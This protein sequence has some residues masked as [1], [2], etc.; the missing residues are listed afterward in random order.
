MPANHILLSVDHVLINI[1]FVA[2]VVFTPMTSAYWPWWKS[3]WGR[4]IVMLET[5]IA[6]DLLASW[7]FIDFGIASFILQWVTAVFLALTVS[8]IVWR[9]IM[10]WVEQRKGADDDDS[11]ASH[12]TAADGRPAGA[13]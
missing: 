8:I 7:L 3:W 6:G 10:I 1:A 4:N 9:A 11:A 13:A 2:S 12:A 5:C